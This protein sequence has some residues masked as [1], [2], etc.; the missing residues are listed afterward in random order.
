MCVCVCV[1]VRVC[2]CVAVCVPVCVSVCVCVCVH[3]CTALPCGHAFH[4]PCVD[5]W[6]LEQRRACPT[7]RATVP[8]VKKATPRVAPSRPFV[9][10][11]APRLALPAPPPRGFAAVP[12]EADPRVLL[13]PGVASH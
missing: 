13:L 3:R 10:G 2:V 5:K 1:C 7:C 4:A 12:S 11:E 9:V 6:L 8:A